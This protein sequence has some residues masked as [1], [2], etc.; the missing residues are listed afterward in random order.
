MKNIE[1][2]KRLLPTL[3]ITEKEKTKNEQLIT[4]LEKNN[5]KLLKLIDDVLPGIISYKQLTVFSE[6]LAK[7]ERN[8][9]LAT[10]IDTCITFANERIK[11]LQN[12]TINLET[13]ET[14]IK[15]VTVNQETRERSIKAVSVIRLLNILPPKHAVF[16]LLKTQGEISHNR[17]KEICGD[18]QL[19]DNVKEYLWSIFLESMHNVNQQK[20]GTRDIC[21]SMNNMLS[22]MYYPTLLTPTLSPSLAKVEPN[23]FGLAAHLLNQ[24]AIEFIVSNEQNATYEKY[25]DTNRK[26][27]IANILTLIATCSIDM[28]D[29]IDLLVLLLDSTKNKEFSNFKQAFIQPLL[30]ELQKSNLTG[31]TL[32]LANRPEFLDLE[33]KVPGIKSAKKKIFEKHMLNFFLSSVT[34]FSVITPVVLA[35]LTAV[36][37]MFFGTPWI[38]FLLGLCSALLLAG[39]AM[40]KMQ[41]LNFDAAEPTPYDPWLLKQFSRMLMTDKLPLSTD[42]NF[43]NSL[44]SQH[45][46]LQNFDYLSAENISWSAIR[47][48]MSEMKTEM[49]SAVQPCH[50]SFELAVYGP[51]QDQLSSG[52]ANIVTGLAKIVPNV[53]DTFVGGLSNGIIENNFLDTIGSTIDPSCR[54]GVSGLLQ[55]LKGAGQITSPI[56]MPAL[57]GVSTILCQ[58]FGH[59]L[60]QNQTSDIQL[61]Q[62][63][64]APK[65]L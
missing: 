5:Q 48:A 31:L 34:S 35:G 27:F 29:A 62:P 44:K 18:E 53:P 37:T 40:L 52:C 65:I 8:K 24:L 50:D 16:L 60:S 63:M 47:K 25:D 55:F 59:F 28:M 49:I 32:L 36:S 19:N 6:E 4:Y 15:N 20:K 58:R 23:R 3:Q 33:N 45:L 11:K 14:S 41:E 22:K 61:Q 13:G 43:W 54:L 10:Q 51:S 1:K 17:L 56:T 38:G 57:R 42:E 9:P 21:L 39:A 46:Q 12:A 2:F 26:T 64:M 30:N 7:V